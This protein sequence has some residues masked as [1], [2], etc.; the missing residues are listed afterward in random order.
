MSRLPVCSSAE[1]VLQVGAL[2]PSSRESALFGP[3]LT[4]DP[5]FSTACHQDVDNTGADTAIRRLLRSRTF[6]CP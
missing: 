6:R 5:G 2:A 4:G 1:A 3:T